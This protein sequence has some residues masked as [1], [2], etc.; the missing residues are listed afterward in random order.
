VHDQRDVGPGRVAVAVAQQCG[1]VEQTVVKAAGAQ[2]CPSVV[3][4]HE[5]LIVRLGR[6]EVHV[7]PTGSRLDLG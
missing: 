5:E 4:H 7:F 1:D 6:G 3:R 2:R